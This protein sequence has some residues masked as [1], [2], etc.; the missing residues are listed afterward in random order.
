MR[1][2]QPGDV[3]RPLSEPIGG[4]EFRLQIRQRDSHCEKQ[5]QS[6]PALF[7]LQKHE[8][9]TRHDNEEPEF[10]VLTSVQEPVP[11]P[12]TLCERHCDQLNRYKEEENAADAH[13][14]SRNV[15]G[16][17][18]VRPAEDRT[19]IHVYAIMIHPYRVGWPSI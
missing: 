9:Q 2:Q 13:N 18:R 3:T 6:T 11:C 15:K 17:V 12:N 8:A 10:K 4:G 5:V 16:S 7:S 1:N 14:D 19:G